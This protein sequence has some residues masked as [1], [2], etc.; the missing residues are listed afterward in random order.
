MYLGGGVLEVGLWE[1]SVKVEGLKWHR[2]TETKNP[3]R[4]GQDRGAPAHLQSE[5]KLP[6]EEHIG[7]ELL[8]SVRVPP[9]RYTPLFILCLTPTG[10]R[11]SVFLYDWLQVFIMLGIKHQHEAQ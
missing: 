1:A 10:G 8:L 3:K 2:S 9:H 5:V 11:E 4:L 7:M 6:Q